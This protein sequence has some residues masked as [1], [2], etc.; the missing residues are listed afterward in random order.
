VKS[1]GYTKEEM[2]GRPVFDLYHPDSIENAKKAFQNHV[3][4]GEVRDVELQFMRKDGSKI[5]VSLNRTSVKDKF[6]NILYSRSSWR[7][8]TERKKIER[9]IEEYTTYKQADAKLRQEDAKIRQEDAKI[10]QAD[11]KIKGEFTAMVSHE[12]RTPLQVIKGGVDLVLNE[13]LGPIDDEQR[14]QLDAVK[15]N[16]DRLTRLI[17]DVLDYQKL[18]S[19]AME[20]QMRPL[21]MN[22]LIRD[23]AELFSPLA[24]EKGLELVCDLKS[25]LS[26][27]VCDKDK[28][29]QVLVNFIDNAVK[30]TNQGSVSVKS[31]TRDDSILV[32]VCD[33]GIGIKVEDQLK[34]FENFAQLPTKSKKEGSGLGLAICKKIVEGHGGVI[35]VNSEYGKGS[36]F[37]FKLPNERRD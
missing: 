13:T 12:L 17:H 37:Y 18:D 31:E 27:V 20:F 23:T 9:Q 36:T 5:D 32:S 16:V 14:E 33:E 15:R 22:E 1:L 4:M 34:I 28:I 19:G 7:D 29:A 3:E 8:I 10:R 2:I 35:G 21:N 25:D 30:F 24:K 11:A 6:G 26:N